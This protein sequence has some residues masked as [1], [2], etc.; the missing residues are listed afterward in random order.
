[1]QPWPHGH[2]HLIMIPTPHACST[3]C[4]V[5]RAWQNVQAPGSM[6]IIASIAIW[7]SERSTTIAH[8]QPS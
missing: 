7:R 5:G 3:A 8:I 2:L 6:A 4:W 1:M